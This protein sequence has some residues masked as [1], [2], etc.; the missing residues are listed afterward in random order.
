MNNWCL[1]PITAPLYIGALIS[2]SLPSAHLHIIPVFAKFL[3]TKHRHSLIPKPYLQLT[4]TL[5]HYIICNLGHHTVH[6]TVPRINGTLAACLIALAQ[7]I[8]VARGRQ[9]GQSGQP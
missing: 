5:V 9:Y 7:T 2:G 1:I 8:L 6:A 4:N 3:S